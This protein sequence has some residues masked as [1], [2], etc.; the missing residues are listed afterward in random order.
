MCSRCIFGEFPGGVPVVKSLPCNAG[1]VGSIRG[2]GTK[3]PHAAGQ[4]SPWAATRVHVPQGEIPH[5]EGKSLV[6]K[7]RPYPAKKKKK[8]DF[9]FACAHIQIVVLGDT[10]M[11]LPS[12]NGKE[13]STRTRFSGCIH[14]VVCMPHPLLR[15]AREPPY[16]LHL[17][18]QK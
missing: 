10:Y 13:L 8:M 9:G 1:D 17:L 7:V 5:D 18:P 15:T 11:L 16:F 4:L 3:I 2:Q 6:P 14:A 12:V